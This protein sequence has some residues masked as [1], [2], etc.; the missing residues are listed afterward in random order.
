MYYALLKAILQHPQNDTICKLLSLL[1]HNYFF[2]PASKENDIAS[3]LIMQLT[4]PENKFLLESDMLLNIW[5]KLYTIKADIT[6]MRKLA[7]GVFKLISSN[8]SE[9][10]KKQQL[11]NHVLQE[12]ERIDSFYLNKEDGVASSSVSQTISQSAISQEALVSD[13]NSEVFTKNITN[14]RKLNKNNIT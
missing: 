5:C 12:L 14:I 8:L 1:E 9:K 3:T 13:Y 2:W 11:E 10:E 4:K 7:D 6:H